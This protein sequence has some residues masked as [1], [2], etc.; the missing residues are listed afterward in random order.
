[1]KN[2]AKGII[3]LSVFFIAIQANAQTLPVREPEMNRPSMFLDLPQKIEVP[4]I[5]LSILLQSEMGKPVTFPFTENVIF[6]G[7][8]TSLAS[9]DDNSVKSV[10]IKS[11]NFNGAVFSFS[12]IIKEDGVSTYVG[13]IL[14]FQHGDAYEINMENGRYYFVKKSFYD[15]VNE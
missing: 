13:R 1:M 9:S 15:L 3:C 4:L 12:R 10:V 5:N 14:S 6:Q 11:T 2:L 8:V 7:V